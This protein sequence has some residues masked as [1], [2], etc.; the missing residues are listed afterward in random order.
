MSKMEL[1]NSEYEGFIKS[2]TLAKQNA[3]KS[4]IE[5]ANVLEEALTKLGKK[6]WVNW[7]S[8]TRINLQKSQAYKFV[9]L[10]LH[11]RNSVQLTGLLKNTNIEK[12]YLITKIKEPEKQAEAAE[13]IIEADYTVKQTKRAVE[14]IN[15]Q[16][17]LDDALKQAKQEHFSQRKIT[18]EKVPKELYEKLKQDYDN[19]LAKYNQ[20]KSKPIE[21]EKPKTTNEPDGTI[22]KENKLYAYKGYWLPLSDWM[23]ANTENP[24]ETFRYDAIRN[25]QKLYNLNLE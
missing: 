3:Q 21:P 4:F 15:N 8:D 20:L 14:L 25:A 12:A 2:Y 10:S 23:N 1:L 16:V 22:D 19:L 7:L 9:A 17:P 13:E 11:C 5:Y 24:D 18:P 6:Q